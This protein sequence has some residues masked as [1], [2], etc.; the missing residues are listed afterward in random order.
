MTIPLH[1][2]EKLGQKLH[3]RTNHP[4][5]II[6]K[7]IR[8]LFPDF[9]IADDLLP[10]V[11]TKDNFDSLRI[12]FDHPS[13]SESDTYYYDSTHVLRTHTSAHQVP[14]LKEGQT[15]FLVCG[16]VYRKDDIDA[17]HYPV[18]HQLEGVKLCDNPAEDLKQTLEL[19][20]KELFDVEFRFKEDY[21][22]FTHP[23]WE[24]EVNFEGKWLEILGCGVIHP[25]VLANAGIQN[26][27]GWAFG[28]GLE[29]L[30]MI[31]F[32]IPDIRYFWS[33][34]SRFL[35]QFEDGKTSVFQ[36]YSKC[37]PCFKD[38]AFWLTPNFNEKEMYDLIRNLGGNLIESVA[39][40]DHFEDT[41]K[42]RVSN[43][44]RIIYRHFDRTLTNDEINLLNNKIRE[45]ISSTFG[46]T[47]R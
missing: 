15:K 11:D 47:L 34:D 9:Y 20:I 33:T 32:K 31:L 1:I 23:S 28:L 21:F 14:L 24:V 6:F 12:P 25:E 17:T 41:K 5:N 42:N 27:T 29:R 10:L 45:K 35:S 44:Y 19:V 39:L 22:P 13:R 8:K 40:L 7:K 46:V 4:I 16:D 43:C 36:P 37:P 2:Q 3:L 30:A 26:Q 38:T 18:F